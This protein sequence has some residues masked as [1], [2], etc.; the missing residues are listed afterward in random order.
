MRI[1]AV[2]LA[3]GASR[4][5]GDECKLV[6]EVHGT[7]MVRKVALALRGADLAEIVA[8]TGQDRLA[9][10]DA[11][12]GLAVRF[13]H[14]ED[15]AQ[16]MG[17]S[18][19]VGVASLAQDLDGAFIVPGDMAY[20]TSDLLM[21]LVAAFERSGGQAIVYPVTSDGG[22]RNPVLWPARC[23]PALGALSGQEGAKALLVRSAEQKITLPVDDP[24]LLLDVDTLADLE[25]ARRER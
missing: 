12:G 17:T 11:L 20:L 5:F 4:R 7:P 18:I 21:Q 8:V 23:S 3:A 10:R 6:A 14:N 25:A 22:Q 2:L 15:W 24:R 9:C 16:G 1:G 19:A 13:A